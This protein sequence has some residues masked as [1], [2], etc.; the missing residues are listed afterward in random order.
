MIIIANPIWIVI[1]A[2]NI[3]IF[4]MLWRVMAMGN[5]GR[6]LGNIKQKAEALMICFCNAVDELWF[7]ITQK[8]LSRRGQLVAATL[9]LICGQLLLCEIAGLL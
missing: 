6:Q 1:E 7:R 5:Y 2:I 4:L 3:A 9:A 8:H